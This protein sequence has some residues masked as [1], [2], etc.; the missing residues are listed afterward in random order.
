MF[1]SQSNNQQQ[2]GVIRIVS[3]SVHPSL[4]IPRV[5]LNIT[6]DRIISTFNQLNLG[7]IDRVDMVRKM[8]ERGEAYQRVFIHF[9]SWST[10]ENA[11]RVRQRILSGKDVKIVY[12]DPWFWKVSENKA[13]VPKCEPHI[14]YIPDVQQMMDDVVREQMG[15]CMQLARDPRTL[16]RPL[17]MPLSVPIARGLQPPPPTMPYSEYISTSKSLSLQQ[18]SACDVDEHV[19]HTPTRD[20]PRSPPPRSPVL[21]QKMGG[22]GKGEGSHSPVGPPPEEWTTV[23]KPVK[24]VAPSRTT[25]QK[26]MVN[27]GTVLKKTVL[28]ISE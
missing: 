25:V 18:P 14:Q 21:Q 24:N 8:N 7:T 9:K 19:S 4:C 16:S 5:F 10:S 13:R 11:I 28:K 20:P 3:D 27:K 15:H 6:R 26:K 23:G 17:P 2:S 12:D 1:S 22:K